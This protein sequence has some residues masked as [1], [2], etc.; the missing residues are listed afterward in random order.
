[1]TVEDA[2]TVAGGLVNTGDSAGHGLTVGVGVGGDVSGAEDGG[3][4]VET[5][6]VVRVGEGDGDGLPDGAAPETTRSVVEA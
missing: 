4:G 1:V 5:G 3:V 6:V 2:A